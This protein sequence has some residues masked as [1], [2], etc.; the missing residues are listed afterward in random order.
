MR[1]PAFYFHWLQRDNPTGTVDRYPA[2]QGYTSS[3][4]GIYCVGDLTG[5]P[6]IKLAAES[7]YHVIEQLH[8]D[9]TFRKEA[10]ATADS[11]L[12]DL[13]IIGAGPAGMAAALRAQAL[14][15]RVVL[16]E[17]AQPFNTIENFPKG[18]PIYV[19][20]VDPPM[21][22]ELSFGDGSKET[23]LEELKQHVADRDIPLR[24]GED[25]EHIT[26]RSGAFEVKTASA[27]YAARRVIIAIGKSGNAQF[28]G[29][30]G[31][32]LP[33]V[34]TRLIDPGEHHAQDILVV[35]GGDSA[36]EAAIALARTGN[37]ITLAYRRASF[38]RPKAHNLAALNA[39]VE[40]GLIHPLFETTVKEIREDEVVLVTPEGE[41]TLPNNAVY[42]LIGTEMPV[43]FFKRS[44]IR[45]EGQRDAAWWGGLLTLLS[46]FTMLYFGKSG[47]AVN[48]FE[49]AHNPVAWLG[50]YLTAPWRV[51]RDWSLAHHA[52][53]G[54]LNFLLG[55]GGSLLFLVAGGWMLRHM[56]RNW[57]RYFGSAW[58]KIKYGYFIGVGLTFFNVYVQGQL[59]QDASWV[60]APTYYYSL[61]YTL[62]ILIFG[63]RRM[64]RTPT[65]YIIAQTSC[66]ITIQTL[67]L[68]LIPFVLYDRFIA[69]ALS[70]GLRQQLFP[71]GKWSSF[72]FVLFWPLNIN[73]FG[74]SAFWTW[75]PFVQ[76]FGILFLLVYL[77]GKGA[78]CGW[79][80][81]CGA[82]A[83]TLGDE[84]RTLAPHGP[85]AKKMENTGQVV[86]WAIIICSMV[87][88]PG[89]LCNKVDPSCAIPALAGN[90][91][92]AYKF[93]IDVIFAG[94]LGLGVYF[95]Y[96]GRIWCRFGCPLAALM[97]IYAR[98]TRYRI[99]ANK[100][101]CISCN[102]CTKVCHMGID[103][104]GF[105]SRGLPMNDV[106]CV[107]CSA[108]VVSCPMQVLTFASIGRADPDNTLYK[109]KPIPLV[110]NW[111]AG[112]PMKQ[113]K[114]RLADEAA[115]TH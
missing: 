89:K 37:R 83:E 76:T 19:T 13:A 45:M 65:P 114:E 29:V 49:G 100:K 43:A 57:D 7:G 2:L 73:E 91:W 86:L 20:P 98:F 42:T 25:V 36:L 74:N 84:Y 110:R 78:Y 109:K 8:G 15:Y 90:F 67:F 35:G 93:V 61:L 113:L 28:L 71:S 56:F 52:W 34:F 14:G 94:V 79:I 30:P 82:M 38:S 1:F 54:S 51:E 69:G 31:E 33:K 62:T 27:S 41:H 81:S 75:F 47:R 48:I 59:M 60:E 21:Q 64:Q 107:R 40:E 46:F 105:A 39:A 6:L 58:G 12:H 85:R 92:Y 9:D 112:L 32:A 108:C 53:Y 26:G 70:D 115:N 80:C 88:I 17:A 87:Y 68:F 97:H 50:A 102:I 106:E 4:P 23:L 96:G 77:F 5:I 24:A 63:I 101:R 99:M 72:A 16:I 44:R 55:W 95:Y 66:L 22:S 10:A 18:K 111:T 11:D 103:V 3:V 104:M